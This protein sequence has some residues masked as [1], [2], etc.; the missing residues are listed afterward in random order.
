MGKSNKKAAVIADKKFCKKIRTQV[1]SILEDKEFETSD[2]NDPLAHKYIAM[3]VI[4]NM[5][6]W[7]TRCGVKAAKAGDEEMA[8]AWTR[9][10]GQL[11][12][13]AKL[14]GSICVGSDDKVSSLYADA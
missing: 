7:H 13:I 3:A 4:S 5:I 10:A 2:I 9:D 11:Q 14:L 12:A 6:D 8:I 1:E